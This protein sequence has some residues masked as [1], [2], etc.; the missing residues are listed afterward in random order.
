LIF[1]AKY[2]FSQESLDADK[3]FNVGLKIL[4]FNNHGE[5]VTT[6]IWYPTDVEPK[7]FTYCQIGQNAPVKSKVAL[8]APVSLKGVYPLVVFAHGLYGCGYDAA[9]LM[10][11]LAGRGYICA[12][13]DFI[14]TKPPQ[15]QE[16]IAFARIK[17]GNVGRPLQLVGYAFRFIK[18][19]RSKP[20]LCLAYVAKQRLIPVRI[21]LDS[22]LKLNQNSNSIF[23]KS[24][25]EDQIAMIGH[26]L[27]G[28]TTLGSIGANPKENLFTD[29][30]IKAAITLSPSVFPYENGI[31][32]IH[33][34]L[35]EMIGECEEEKFAELG[36]TSRKILY[37]NANPPKYW[38]LL[39][40]GTHFSFTNQ[41]CEGLPLYIGVSRL[42]EVNVICRY[43]YAFLEKYLKD[44]KLANIQLNKSDPEWVEYLKE[45]ISIA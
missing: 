38:G 14:D 41:A 6:A 25:Q 30:R 31:Q 5:K 1:Q 10:E 36:K 16:Q 27:G 28:A 37:E 34:P 12:A 4:D 33:I 32:N 22:M 7:L 42:P 3:K 24:I 40:D 23:Y 35:M 21:V 43:G 8:N 20:D 45:D 9:Y 39:K 13:P 26:S 44:S 2:I 17:D 15:Y 11:Y 18:D 19:M 29:P